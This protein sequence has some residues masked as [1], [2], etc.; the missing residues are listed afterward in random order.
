MNT[1]ATHPAPEQLNSEAITNAAAWIHPLRSEIAKHLVGQEVLVDRLIIAL[2]VKGHILLEGVPGLAK[3]LAL[4]TLASLVDAD[5]HRLQFTPDMLPADIVGTQ[6]FDPKTSEF[7]VKHGP[8][9]ANFILADEINRAPAKVQSALLEA[10]QEQQVTIG[11]HSFKLPRPFLVMATQN[12]LE[13]E[14]TYPLPEAQV[15]RFM[16]KVV[17]DYPS[18]EEELRVVDL[19]A[20]TSEIAEPRPVVSLEQISVAREVVN[21][22]Y[23]DDKVKRYLV[24][25]VH[26]TRNPD[27]FG[28][29]LGPYLRVGASPRASISLALAGKAHAFLE[30]RGYVTPHDIK[31]VAMDVLRHRV[32]VSYEAEAEGLTSEHLVTRILD[33]L[34]VP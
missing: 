25:L 1:T 23:L 3:T 20:T 31:S 22:L 27:S 4:K 30:G 5:F 6:I 17:V 11:D 33:Q 24:T 29:N 7:K 10:M 13:Q 26:A 16:L 18:L 34:P 2:L 32:T 21:S 19:A 28:L 14:G 8:V 12:P 15:D 9:F